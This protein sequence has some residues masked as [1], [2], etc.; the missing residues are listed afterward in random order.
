MRHW[1]VLLISTIAFAK[2]LPFDLPK[3]WSAQPQAKT[4]TSAAPPDDVTWELQSQE[5]RGSLIVYA[6]KISEGE[7]DS[8]AAEKHAAKIKNRVAWGMKA[9]AGPPRESLKIGGRRA[10]R[11][12]DRVG[13]SLGD[14]EQ[15][16]TCLIHSS[17]L[18]CVV[19]IA[20]SDLRDEVESAAAGMLASLR[21]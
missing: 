14:E 20:R 8:A 4:A 6:G 11:W 10:V 3:G 13:G 1:A 18:A 21:R 7:L 15:L 2:G 17:K 12:R 5:A 19:T 16:M 9:A